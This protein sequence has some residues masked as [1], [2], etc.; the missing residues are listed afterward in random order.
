[1]LTCTLFVKSSGPLIASAGQSAINKLLQGVLAKGVSAVGF[2]VGFRSACG[3]FWMLAASTSSGSFDHSPS[4]GS[5]PPFWALAAA[6]A[7]SASNSWRSR[8][9][10]YDR[11]QAAIGLGSMVG[12]ICWVAL[13]GVLLPVMSVPV[14]G[15]IMSWMKMSLS[16]SPLCDIGKRQVVVDCK[17]ILLAVNCAEEACGFISS[18]LAPG[19][20]VLL[21]L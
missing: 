1:M 4:D 21:V 10:T 8:S 19:S 11:V 18:G 6:A 2:G 15:M 14:V 7:A 16:N 13:A 12:F 20:S 17:E 5:G 9:W 3:V